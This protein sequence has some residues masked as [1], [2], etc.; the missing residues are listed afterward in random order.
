MPAVVS[1]FSTC[2]S[3][4]D[5]FKNAFV[6]SFS[7][8][9]SN[10]W[11]YQSGHPRKFPQDASATVCPF[12]AQASKNGSDD[13]GAQAAVVAHALASGQAPKMSKSQIWWTPKWLWSKM[14]LLLVW[15]NSKEDGPQ[16]GSNRKSD[17]LWN[18]WSRKLDS[19]ENGL[20][21]NFD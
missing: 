20:N 13:A 3:C 19:F 6:S 12:P 2:Y 11:S 14:S 1:A 4:I 16:S 7:G 9:G 5:K 21:H 8:A 18:C 17:A 15:F 10:S